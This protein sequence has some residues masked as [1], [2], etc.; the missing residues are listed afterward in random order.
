[1]PISKPHTVWFTNVA[2]YNEGRILCFVNSTKAKLE[3]D[4]WL[5]NHPFYNKSSILVDT[6]GRIDKFNKKYNLI[7]T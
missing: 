6:E 3:I 7:G 4:L 5:G 2:I 1:M